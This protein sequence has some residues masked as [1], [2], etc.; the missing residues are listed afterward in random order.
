MELKICDAKGN[1]HTLEMN[2]NAMR[3][4]RA[5]DGLNALP[6][7]KFLERKLVGACSCRQAR[8]SRHQ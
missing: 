6:L 7:D 4:M 2:E 5:E 3:D 8:T 1:Q